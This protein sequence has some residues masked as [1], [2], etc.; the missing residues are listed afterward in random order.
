MRTT[1]IIQRSFPL[2]PIVSFTDSPTYD[3]AKALS[4]LLKSLIRK[5][6]HHV[7]NS[8]DLASSIAHELLQTDEI[9]SF[10]VVSLF[11]EVPIQLTL[12]ITKQ[13]LQSD[14]ELSQV[15]HLPI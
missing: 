11:T 1:E 2:R 6:E 9:G 5:S 3:L 12:N 15:C 10:D 14:P 7:R 4:S 8:S 13:R